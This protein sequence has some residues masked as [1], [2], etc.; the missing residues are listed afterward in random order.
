LLWLVKFNPDLVV[1][2]YDQYIEISSPIRDT[3][4]IALLW[5]ASLLTEIRRHQSAPQRRQDLEALVR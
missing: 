1:A 5:K 4:S 3:D 2:R